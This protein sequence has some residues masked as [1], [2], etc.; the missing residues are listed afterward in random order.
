MSSVLN[1][2][3][4]PAIEILWERFILKSPRLYADQREYPLRLRRGTIECWRLKRNSR[5]VLRSAARECQY[6][7]SNSRTNSKQFADSD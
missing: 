3:L 5:L 7:C 6:G 2:D 1:L 4:H